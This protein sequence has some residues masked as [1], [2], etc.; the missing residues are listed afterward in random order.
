MFCQQRKKIKNKIRPKT[1][2][3]NYKKTKTYVDLR[4]VYVTSEKK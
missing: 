1:E 3:K 4:K 2:K